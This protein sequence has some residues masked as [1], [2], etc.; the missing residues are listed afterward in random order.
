MAT[1][2]AA[3]QARLGSSVVGCLANATLTLPA[4]A[5]VS[6]IYE[7]RPSL[8]ALA[9]APM[10]TRER[11][12]RCLTAALVE[13]VAK[14]AAVTLTHAGVAQPMRIQHMVDRPELA[15]TEIALEDA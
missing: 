13:V 11:T 1:D 7:P 6:G 12:F 2:F 4:G 14:G 15:Q 3:A 9:A 10:L 8:A 5:V